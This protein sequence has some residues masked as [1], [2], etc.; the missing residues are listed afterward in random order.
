MNRTNLEGAVEKIVKNHG[1]SFFTSPDSSITQ[2][3]ESYPSACLNPL[4][5][6]EIDSTK[7]G[8]AIY[9]IRLYLMQLGTKLSPYEQRVALS[10]METDLITIFMQLSE[11]DRVVA[12]EDLTIE[13]CSN[14]LTPHGDISQRATAQIVTYF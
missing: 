6:R 12:V 11:S 9:D 2:C 13:P 5:L 4:S 3:V 8:R 10:R 14:S 7:H 1:Y